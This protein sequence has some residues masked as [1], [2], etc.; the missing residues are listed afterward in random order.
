[1]YTYY[2]NFPKAI[3]AFITIPFGGSL[4]SESPQFIRTDKAIKQAL[5]T[6]LKNKPFEKITV[7]DILDET[8]VTRST[9]YK[10]FSDKYEIVEKLQEDFFVSQM[11]IRK[12][13]FENSNAFTTYLKQQSLQNQE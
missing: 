10:H 6:L 7:Q 5:I 2:T 4:M 3:F 8:P 13:L 1:M 12:A 9:F 11:E